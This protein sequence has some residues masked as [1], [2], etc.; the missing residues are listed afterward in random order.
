MGYWDKGL[1]DT[2]PTIEVDGQRIDSKDSESILIYPAHEQ[3]DA[4]LQSWSVLGPHNCFE[5][6]LE[7][8]LEEFGT[9]FVLLPA[10]KIRAYVKL[11]SKASDSQV[12]YGFVQYSSNPLDRSLTVKDISFSYQKEFRFYV[13]ECRKDEIESKTLQLKGL[14]K[15]LLEAASL[16]LTSPSGEIRYCSLGRKEV[17]TA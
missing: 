6:S 16:K 8:M 12:R 14:G 9:Y 5:Q 10:K 17:V 7:R 4:W 2:M 3:K 15:M 11:L 1:G 13:G